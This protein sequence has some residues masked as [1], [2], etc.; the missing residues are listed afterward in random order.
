MQYLNWLARAAVLL[1]LFWPWPAEAAPIYWQL[2]GE[3]TYNPPNLPGLPYAELDQ[4]L[5]VGTDVTFQI[6]VDPAAPDLCDDPGAGFYYLPAASMSFGGNSYAGTGW[7]EVHNILANCA[8]S[9]NDD[10][11]LRVSLPFGLATI[12][13]GTFNGDALPTTPPPFARLWVGSFDP[14]YNGFGDCSED[15]PCDLY[16]PVNA[17]G[18]ITSSAVVPEPSTLVL[19]LPPLSAIV[20][21]HR[22]RR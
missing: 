14:N 18:E 7:M 9:G 16:P 17:F 4:L 5:P 12:E 2:N 15:F 20:V 1:C 13:F 6:T 21:R 19:M 8:Y 10:T 3:I 11:L 22:R